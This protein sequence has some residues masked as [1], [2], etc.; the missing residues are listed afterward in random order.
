[1][2]TLWTAFA[3]KATTGRWPPRRVEQAHRI[4]GFVGVR[5]STLR[6][7]PRTIRDLRNSGVTDPLTASDDAHLLGL[8]EQRVR[9]DGSVTLHPRWEADS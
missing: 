5:C 6:L 7:D 4:A 2:S 1:M 3:E 9:G 8:A